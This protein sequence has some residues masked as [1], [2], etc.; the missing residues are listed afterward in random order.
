VGA[1]SDLNGALEWQ[2]PQGSHQGGSIFPAGFATTIS[3][4]GST[5][6]AA[7]KWQTAEAILPAGQTQATVTIDGSTLTAPITDDVN[8]LEPGLF[9]EQIP[10]KDRLV[11]QINPATGLF[12][13]S[14]LDPTTHHLER[15]AGAVFQKQ[16]LAA[17]FFCTQT[18]NGSLLLANGTAGIP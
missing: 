14:F 13:G 16:A 9:K 18:S 15:V 3:A 2:R 12:T 1:E 4:V 7:A 17:G 8:L 10:N 6:V 5:Y 11:L